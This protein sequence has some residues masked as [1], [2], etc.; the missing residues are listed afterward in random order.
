MITLFN[1]FL[2]FFSVFPSFTNIPNNV[3]VKTGQDAK[4]LCNAQGYP[5]P[6][7]SWSKDGGKNFPAAQDRRFQVNPD[8]LNEFIIRN[9]T[10]QDRGTYFCNATNIAG[11]II[12]NATVNVM[13][14]LNLC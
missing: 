3:T 8:N 7:L 4:F 6:Y 9:V 13:G 14:T 1:S 12:S 5:Q 10:W 2:C 11:S